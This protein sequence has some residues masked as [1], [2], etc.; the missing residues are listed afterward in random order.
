MVVHLRRVESYR[1]NR[2]IEAVKG[3]LARLEAGESI[4]MA[5]V[6]VG[7]RGEVATACVNSDEGCYHALNSGAARLAH[8]LA[9]ASD[10]E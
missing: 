8:S 1:N 10:D 6:E 2:A 7:R 4:A 9:G 3:L 5:F